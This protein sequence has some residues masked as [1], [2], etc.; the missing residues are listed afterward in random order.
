M[1]DQNPLHIPASIIGYIMAGMLFFLS[2]IFTPDRLDILQQVGN[3]F[4]FLFGGLLWFGVG[5]L[6]GWLLRK[7]KVKKKILMLLEK[8]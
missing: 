6:L 4:A 3:I 8:D 2:N 7:R 1:I 5:S